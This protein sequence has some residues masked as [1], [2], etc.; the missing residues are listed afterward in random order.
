MFVWVAQ[1]IDEKNH[2]M[3]E[4]TRQIV[5]EVDNLDLGEFQNKKK[6]VLASGS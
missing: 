6:K 3:V 5:A 4:C 2:K 1:N